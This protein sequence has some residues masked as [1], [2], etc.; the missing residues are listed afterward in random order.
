MFIFDLVL[1]Y[2]NDVM[3]IF[4]V[5][6]GNLEVVIFYF[7]LIVDGIFMVEIKVLVVSDKLGIV[8]NF[9]F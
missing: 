1:N 2:L 9:E 5:V 8:L 3:F 7:K 4:N 6:D